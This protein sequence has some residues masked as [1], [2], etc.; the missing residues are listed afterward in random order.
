MRRGIPYLI[1]LAALA[2][3]GCEDTILNKDII[4]TWINP[5]GAELHF[6]ANGRFSYKNLPTAIFH[7]QGVK[8]RVLIS[9]EGESWNLQLP[10][11]AGPSIYLEFF[12]ID[13]IKD[14]PPITLYV[15]GHMLY[16]KYVPDVKGVYDGRFYF[17]KKP[18][19]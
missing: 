3:A 11:D 13:E 12:W 10:E 14:R 17:E 8:E 1:L 18:E 2:L 16:F 7:Y 15:S 19:K 4:G 9:G 6:E 5:S